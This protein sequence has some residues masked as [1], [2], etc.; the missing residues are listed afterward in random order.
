MSRRNLLEVKPSD[1]VMS[2]DPEVRKGCSP[3]VWNSTVTHPAFAK[4]P[5]TRYGKL[6]FRCANRGMS[7]STEFLAAASSS[8]GSS[9]FRSSTRVQRSCMYESLRWRREECI[10]RKEF[11][12]LSR[13]RR[14][15]R[16]VSLEFVFFFLL[17]LN[18]LSYR[19]KKIYWDWINCVW[20]TELLWRMI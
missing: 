5:V 13:S 8:R 1:A 12:Y 16:L 19:S 2:T 6:A 7:D 4:G 15:I 3:L 18:R 14:V 10:R 20:I 17:P 9:I 11:G